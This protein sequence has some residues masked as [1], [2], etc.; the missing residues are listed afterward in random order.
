MTKYSVLFSEGKIGNL[1]TKNRLVMPPMVLNYADEMGLVTPKYLAHIE[2]IACGGVGTMI[3]EASFISQDGR[4]F[5]NELGLHTDEVI[6]GLKKLVA[7]A[8]SQRAAIGPQLYHAG[9]QTSFKVTGTKPVAPSAI[10]DPVINEMP[11]SLSVE[12]IHDIV[13]AY[14]QAAGRAKE[15]GCD[16]VEIHGAHGYLITQ[17]LSPYSN[18][19]EDEYG[20]SE[21]NRMRFASEVVQ[22]VRGAVG[23]EFPLIMRLSAQEMVPGGLRLPDSMKIARRLEDLGVDAL[24]VSVGNYASFSHGYM[25]S[26]MAMPDSLLVPFA[27][28]I[29]R[30]VD[31]PVIAVGKIRHPELAE[32]I[33]STG[34]A[35]FVALGRSLLADPDWPR[36]AQEGL[37]LEINK[38]VACNQ[39][40]I[41]RLFDGKDVWCTVNPETSR[42]TEF[43][44]PLPE[45]V[46]RVL[47]AGGGPAGMQ[48]A[49]TAA[50]RGHQVMLCEETDS[51]GGALNL[52]AALPLRPGW[53]EL[54]NHLIAEMSRLGIDIRL[55]TKVTPELA[56]RER[57]DV[58]IV[59]TG[60]LEARPD[61]PG[62]DLGNVM[63][64]HEILSGKVVAR[65]KVVVLGGGV[66]G[67]M[68]ADHL[69]RKGHEVTLVGTGKTIARAA[70]A[71][72][73]Y[74]LLERL[75]MG[76][77]TMLT[78]AR[79]KGIEKGGVIIE[80]MGR[81]EELPADTVAIAMGSVPN[82]GIAD[83]LRSV[84]KE[85]L[86]VGDAVK[87][88]NVTYAMIEGARAGLSI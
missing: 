29:K 68:I 77:V 50:L 60:A 11:R 88:R 63:M 79:I 34:K 76:R 51:L 21:D 70:A 55:R 83:E 7:A 30:S 86:V 78:S 42:E 80:L 71:V 45:S 23:P 6:P 75:R 17:F 57:A 82:D 43:A 66:S 12:E 25:I 46:K 40:C 26:P 4:G 72:E 73:R 27:E 1:K 56:S 65:G 14:A 87:S 61:I 3:L 59:A 41:S 22:A 8:H 47:I 2:R 69:S 54:K 32:E 52:A 67:A 20:G 84:V 81:T 28:A 31:I 18:L 10:P 38:C 44:K 53:V 48:A 74:L 35:D 5:G 64:S 13:E 36:K 49:K 19:R 24:H 37:E 39:G 9:R 62:V 15:S 85:V 16:F 33:V 58:A